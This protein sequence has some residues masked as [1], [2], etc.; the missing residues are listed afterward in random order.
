MLN[1]KAY[2]LK[3]DK[4]QFVIFFV[5]IFE[6]G[7]NFMNEGILCIFQKIFAGNDFEKTIRTM[8]T[9]TASPETQVDNIKLRIR[10][11]TSLNTMDKRV[12]I[13]R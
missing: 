9:I 13:S 6:Q 3:Y 8:L 5:A 1:T 10:L 11:D 4:V 12:S 7:D 2:L